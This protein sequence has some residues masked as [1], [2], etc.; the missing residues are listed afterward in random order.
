[1][2]PTT[3]QASGK[4][5]VYATYFM[6]LDGVVQDPQDWSF[7]FWND[8]THRFKDA[9]LRKTDILLL[10]RKTYEGFAQAWPAR[11][12]LDE[13]STKF[14]TMPKHVLTR[15]LRDA[16]WENSHVLGPDPEAEIR[17]LVAEGGGDIGVH[18]SVSV[19]RWLMQHDMLDE[20]RLLVYPMVRGKGE[21]LFDESTPMDLTLVESKAFPTGVVSMVYRRAARPEGADK[22]SEV[23]YAEAV[24]RTRHL[25]EKA[26]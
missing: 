23:Q 14:N 4:R 8:D 16:A 10:G 21:R 18:G 1:M 2:T 17:K 15:T 24:K 3:N 20:L 19:T 26:A 6:T 5:N 11:K 13:G 25:D 22:P 7:P 9:E 12:G